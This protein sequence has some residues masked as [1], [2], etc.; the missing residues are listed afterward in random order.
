VTDDLEDL[1]DLLLH[2][3]VEA[4]NHQK[5]RR[6]LSTRR[7]ADTSYRTSFTC[8]ENWVLGAQVQLIH[9]EGLVRTLIGL[10]D[11]LKHSYVPGCRRLVAT[12]TRSA[13]LP[14]KLEE[15]TGAHWLPAAAWE[16]RRRPANRTLELAADITLDLGQHLLAQACLLQA[17]LVG[18]GLQRLCLLADTIFEGNTP[19][20]ICT[21]PAGLDILEGLTQECKVAVWGQINKEA[22][23]E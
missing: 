7:E 18:G 21:L 3:Q 8:P 11:E 19:R 4:S 2:A 6:S 9:V 15:V 10:F 14:F 1:E 13:E 17:S 20:T 5:G 22:G 12:G 16:L 23:H